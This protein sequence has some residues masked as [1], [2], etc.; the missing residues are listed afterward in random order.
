MMDFEK[1]IE[2]ISEYLMSVL[3]IKFKVCIDSKL[4]GNLAGCTDADN[5]IFISKSFLNTIEDNVELIILIAHEAFHIWQKKAIKNK[6]VPIEIASQWQYEFDNY[7]DDK[8]SS[9][10]Y[11]SQ[12]IEE[13]ASVFSAILL[14]K[15]IGSDY[16]D[17]S[18]FNAKT[19][20]FINSLN[21]K[22]LK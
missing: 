19:I 6:L 15:I 11:T 13:T 3:D 21:F 7:V 12:S 16:V 5:V 17:S 9:I 8:D 22:F 18:T 14:E 2:Y 20:D 1:N 4:E 10:E